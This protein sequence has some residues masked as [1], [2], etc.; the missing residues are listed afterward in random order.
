MKSKPRFLK[1][2]IGTL[3]LSGAVQ[4]SA[5]DQTILNTSYDIARELF[6]T[7]NPTFEKHW[8]EKTDRKSV[9]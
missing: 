8:L 7:Y 9:V 1:T 5:A 6:A 2:I 3:L 4:A